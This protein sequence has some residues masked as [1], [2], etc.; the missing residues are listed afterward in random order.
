MNMTKQRFY[1]S[2]M[3][4]GSPVCQ[5]R[6]KTFHP[7]W[8]V[9]SLLSS[10]TNSRPIDESNWIPHQQGELLLGNHWSWVGFFQCYHWNLTVTTYVW[11]SSIFFPSRK[12]HHNCTSKNNV[13]WQSTKL[14]TSQQNNGNM[15]P[16]N[17]LALKLFITSERFQSKHLYNLC[18]RPH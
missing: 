1:G 11:E 7:E 9:L 17:T 15:T 12:Y 16:A 3:L 4:R 2:S 10:C 14:P 18:L 5:S 8:T 13:L 6:G